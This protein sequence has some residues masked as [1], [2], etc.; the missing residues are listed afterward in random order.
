MIKSYRGFRHPQENANFGRN[1]RI[2]ERMNL[3]IR[4]EFV[5]IFNRTGLPQPSTGS[6]QTPV[7][8]GAGGGT[9]LTSGYGVVNVYQAP[10]SGAIFQPTS[11]SASSPL[12]PRSGTLIAR[13]TF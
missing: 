8:R 5:N 1:F 6:P 7:T 11:L 2:R 4:A 12:T 3:F 13:F 9:I 10:G